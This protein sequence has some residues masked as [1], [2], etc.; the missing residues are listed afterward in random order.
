MTTTFDQQLAELEREL[1]VRKNIYPRWVQ[2]GKLKQQQA[3]H[4]IHVL[5]DIKEVVRAARQAKQMTST[6]TGQRI[7]QEALEAVPE[8]KD[9]KALV[10]YFSN[11]RGREEMIAA[12]IAALPNAR[13]VKL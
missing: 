5:E 12:C 9:Q 4:R 8:L 13:T 2:E 10:L 1:G 7:D 3:D 11:E 6:L